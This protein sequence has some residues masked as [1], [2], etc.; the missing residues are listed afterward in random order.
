MARSLSIGAESDPASFQPTSIQVHPYFGVGLTHLAGVYCRRWPGQMKTSAMNWR[1]DCH[2]HQEPYGWCPSVWSWDRL[3]HGVEAGLAKTDK[4]PCSVSSRCYR[5]FIFDPISF[6]SIFVLTYLG[7][8]GPSSTLSIRVSSKHWRPIVQHVETR[9]T[10]RSRA[11]QGRYASQ[12]Q[13]H[14]GRGRESFL[15]RPG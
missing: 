3:P 11:I 8:Q 14:H 1:R 2:K 9:Q 13:T 15:T 4:T 6:I 7:G 10:K 12:R 5:R